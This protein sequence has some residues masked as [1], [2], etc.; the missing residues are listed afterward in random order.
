VL[1]AWLAALIVAVLL[2]V[3]AGVLGL[4]GKKSLEKGV[5]PTPERTAENV[6]QDVQAVKE[7][8]RS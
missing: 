2:L 3:V 4:L 6:K 8:I 5:P 7:G 1:D